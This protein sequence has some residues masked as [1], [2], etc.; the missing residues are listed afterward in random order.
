MSFPAQNRTGMPNG[1][2]QYLKHVQKY[3][4]CSN[5]SPVSAAGTKKQAQRTP[6]VVFSPFVLLVPVS[7]NTEALN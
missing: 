4:M 6:G 1:V 3:K 7:F 2:R 5:T